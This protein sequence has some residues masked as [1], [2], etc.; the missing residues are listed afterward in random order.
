M[1]S[2]PWIAG[3]ALVGLTLVDCAK[4]TELAL[5]NALRRRR[6]VAVWSLLDAAAR[7]ILV[8]GL[9]A[10]S[11]QGTRTSIIVGLFLGSLVA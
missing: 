3:A 9:V 1:Q 6:H 2:V 8:I 11:G 7:P 5:L 4:A 10:I